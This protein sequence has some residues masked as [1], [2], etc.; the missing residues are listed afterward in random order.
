MM[1]GRT[2]CVAAVLRIR[3][4]PLVR[5]HAPG[6]SHRDLKRRTVTDGP[7][8][9]LRSWSRSSSVPPPHETPSRVLPTRKFSCAPVLME[10]VPLGVRTPADATAHH[11]NVL[12][13]MYRKLEVWCSYTT[14]KN[15]SLNAAGAL[16]LQYST[17]IIFRCTQMLFYIKTI[18]FE[19]FYVYLI[20]ILS[21]A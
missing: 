19:T 18:L 8:N 17:F 11:N 10:V 14:S 12:T 7:S 13:R 9:M 16:T 5:L 6:L 4:L 15:K 3:A 21:E 1:S 2:C 20:T